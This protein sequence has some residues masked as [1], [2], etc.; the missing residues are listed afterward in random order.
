MRK[1]WCDVEPS[2]DEPTRRQHTE[3]VELLR[4]EIDQLDLLQGA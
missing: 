4:A 3:A 2:T 1:V